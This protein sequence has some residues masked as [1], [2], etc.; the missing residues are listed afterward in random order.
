MS[1]YEKHSKHPDSTVSRKRWQDTWNPNDKDSLREY[2]RQKH[3][4]ELNIPYDRGWRDAKR[5]RKD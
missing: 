4:P 1:D 5:D 3:E 2:F